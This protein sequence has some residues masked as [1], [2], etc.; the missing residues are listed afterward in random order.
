MGE[1]LY[2]TDLAL[3]AGSGWMFVGS[4][5]VQSQLPSELATIL[6]RCG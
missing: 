3:L 1:P 2:F 6:R 4:R 5:H